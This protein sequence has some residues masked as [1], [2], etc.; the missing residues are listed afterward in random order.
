MAAMQDFTADSAF[1]TTLSEV[2]GIFA[3]HRHSIHRLVLRA[4]LFEQ[5][6]DVNAIRASQ[7]D[8]VKAIDTKVERFITNTS[9]EQGQAMVKAVKRLSEE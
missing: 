7:E 2:T 3:Q 4:I 8:C 1:R 5:T 9:P 6:F